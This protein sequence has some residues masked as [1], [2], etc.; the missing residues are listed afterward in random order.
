[1]GAPPR[2]SPIL[3]RGW[4]SAG[5]SFKID[6]MFDLFAGSGARVGGWANPDAGT[7]L[8]R[9]GSTGGEAFNDKFANPGERRLG[10]RKREADK[11]STRRSKLGDSAR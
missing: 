6:M 10:V 9:G 3:L 11:C 8:E 5:S 4:G 1:M 2:G 7:E